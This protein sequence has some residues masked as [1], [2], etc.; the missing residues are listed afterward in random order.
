MACFKP[1]T[2]SH[3]E[4]YLVGF[5]SDCIHGSRL[6]SRKEVLQFF[7]HELK[8]YKKTVRESVRVTIQTVAEFWKK[9]NL[10]MTTTQHAIG[11]LEKV[12]NE[13]RILQKTRKRGGA[14]QQAKEKVLV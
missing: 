1:A 14:T 12:Y 5:T 8:V 3:T 13:W 2:R 10:P 9:S 4:I 7:F 11:R 6:P